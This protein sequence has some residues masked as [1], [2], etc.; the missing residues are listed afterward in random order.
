M[1]N[2]LTVTFFNN[3]DEF[4]CGMKWNVADGRL[5]GHL[6]GPNKSKDA[7]TELFK[8]WWHDYGEDLVLEGMADA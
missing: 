8:E 5:F 4:Y 7:V 6:I 1:N 2:M 3:G